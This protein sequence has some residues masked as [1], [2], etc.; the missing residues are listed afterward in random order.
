MAYRIYVGSYTNEIYTIAFDPTAP[1]LTL[2]STVTVGHHPSW[3]TPLPSDPSVIFA[4][5]E[6]A[7]GE[8]IT[9]KY[10]ENGR[11]TTVGNAPSGGADPCSLVVADDKLLISNV[12]GKFLLRA[13]T[14]RIIF[15]NFCHFP[16][17][18]AGVFATIPLSKEVSY[19]KPAETTSVTFTGTG[20]NTSRQ[21]SSHPHQ[22]VIHPDRQ[23][24]LVPDLGQDKTWRFAKDENG[25]WTQKGFVEYKPGSGPRHLAFH[26]TPIHL[27]ACLPEE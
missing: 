4:G 13:P 27:F 17:Y 12:R 2:L 8:I 26:S 11:G 16:Q 7:E 21:E 22:V 14:L 18:S 23:E 24:I 1:S 9:V 5:L 25:S 15:M 6:Q 10:D 20:P 3:I 19:L